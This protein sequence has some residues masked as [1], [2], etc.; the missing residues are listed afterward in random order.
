MGVKIPRR[1]RWATKAYTSA[2]FLV[3]IPEDFF[4]HLLLIKSWHKKYMNTEFFKMRAEVIT[5]IKF[6]N[7]QRHHKLLKLECRCSKIIIVLNNKYIFLP[8]SSDVGNI[9]SINT[10]GL[11]WSHAHH[12]MPG[13]SN[14]SLVIAFILILLKIN[15][16]QSPLSGASTSSEQP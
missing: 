9:K 16:G 4:V 14:I 6:L 10:S 3:R 5:Y 1:W 2:T 15:P 11:G 12:R 13:K 8:V 7:L